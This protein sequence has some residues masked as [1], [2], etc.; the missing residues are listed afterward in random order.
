MELEAAEWINLAQSW[1][2]WRAIVDTVMNHQ[3]PYK[4]NCFLTS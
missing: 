3:V 1:D 2:R 4:A